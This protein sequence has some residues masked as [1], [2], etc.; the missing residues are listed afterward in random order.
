M[1]ANDT[2]IEDPVGPSP[3]DP[4]SKAYRRKEGVRNI[5]EKGMADTPKQ[6]ADSG[7]VYRRAEGSWYW[8]NQLHLRRWYKGRLRLGF[9]CKVNHGGKLI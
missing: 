7:F 5:F 6:V 1:F 3:M 2:T 4:E 8:N 9:V